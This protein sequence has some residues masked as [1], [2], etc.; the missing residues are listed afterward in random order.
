MQRKSLRGWG[1][2][3]AVLTVALTSGCERARLATE[4]EERLDRA[5]ARIAELGEFYEAQHARLQTRLEN[6][7]NCTPPQRPRMR[8]EHFPSRQAYRDARRAFD[9]AWQGCRRELTAAS[10]IA[11]VARYRADYY[12][13]DELLMLLLQEIR[14]NIGNASGD[15]LRAF[16]G[17][18]EDVQEEWRNLVDLNTRVR[19]RRRGERWREGG[20]TTMEVLGTLGGAFMDALTNQTQ[21]DPRR[22]TTLV[23]Q[24]RRDWNERRV[25]FGRALESAQRDADKLHSGRDE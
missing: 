5:E 8:R 1:V 6:P 7:P 12:Q 21:G 22:L 18:T 24:V 11:D 19:M 23:D 14:L 13:S 2:A 4:A 10:E 3:A 17:P 16:G 15:E 20:G 25:A 9:R